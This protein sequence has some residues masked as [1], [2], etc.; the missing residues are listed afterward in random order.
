MWPRLL[1]SE[2]FGPLTAD[3]DHEK[4]STSLFSFSLNKFFFPTCPWSRVKQPESAVSVE[5]KWHVQYNSYVGGSGFDLGCGGETSMTGSLLMSYSS[6]SSWLIYHHYI[7]AGLHWQWSPDLGPCAHNPLD[8]TEIL[9]PRNSG[10]ISYVALLWASPN[11]TH[12]FEHSSN[13]VLCCALSSTWQL[14]IV[15]VLI[16]N[17]RNWRRH[18]KSYNDFNACFRGTA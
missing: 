18:A 3:H 14:R 6:S 2:F 10:G 17:F 15:K 12:N 16:W 11:P 1:K 7:H 5:T 4:P 8:C 13:H 9:V